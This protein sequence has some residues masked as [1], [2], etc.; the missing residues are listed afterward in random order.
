MGPH[1]SPLV[2]KPGSLAVS[3]RPSEVRGGR[4]EFRTHDAVS[5][6]QNTIYALDAIWLIILAD[7][8]LYPE[9]AIT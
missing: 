4:G 8:G 5:P 9:R 7:R 2:A 3:T 1:V 6:G